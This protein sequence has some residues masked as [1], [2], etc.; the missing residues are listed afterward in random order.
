MCKDDRIG[1]PENRFHRRDPPFVVRLQLLGGL[2]RDRQ[3][4]PR[5]RRKL[6]SFILQRLRNHLRI[7]HILVEII[8][9]VC[10]KPLGLVILQMLLLYVISI[11]PVT[12]DTVIPG[13][14]HDAPC[15][16]ITSVRMLRQECVEPRHDIIIPDRLLPVCVNIVALDLSVLIQN[17]LV[18]E[19]GGLV[20]VVVAAVID[21]KDNRLLPR[22]EHQA[23][24][25]RKVR[26]S[27]RVCRLHNQIAQPYIDIARIV[28]PLCHL[29]KLVGRHHPGIEAVRLRLPQH[30]CIKRSGRIIDQRVV[31]NVRYRR[32]VCRHAAGLCRLILRNRV[33]D[34][35]VILIVRNALKETDG[36]IV[37]ILLRHQLRL[38]N[39]VCIGT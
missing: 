31:E 20:G 7:R 12:E 35:L 4:S 19:P 38:R 39:R 5:V 18:R 22:R 15:A 6:P 27:V 32:H 14:C 10:L 13:H 24:V 1:L 33:R 21:G 36:T 29:I 17:K 26:R 11:C 3:M 23:G 2:V 8:F 30:A 37:V 25:G 28:Q 9:R 16:L 34:G